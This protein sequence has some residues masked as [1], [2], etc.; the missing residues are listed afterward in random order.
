MVSDEN[1][2]SLLEAIIFRPLHMRK[3]LD[4]SKAMF[5]SDNVNNKSVDAISAGQNDAQSISSFFTYIIEKLKWEKLKEFYDDENVNFEKW[6]TL[7]SMKVAFLSHT[8][9]SIITRSIVARNQQKNMNSFRNRN[10]SDGLGK[11]ITKSI[12]SGAIMA[13][14]IG[15]MMIFI[16][17]FAT[18][19]EHFSL[20]T[21]PCATTVIPTIFCHSLGVKPLQA[22]KGGLMLGVFS[23]LIILGIS[24]SYDLS[25]DETYQCFKNATEIDLREERES[26]LYKFMKEHRIRKKEKI[27]RVTSRSICD[28]IF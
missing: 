15:C 20:W 16:T 6:I 12:F 24:F 13:A 18:W 10:V 17:Q 14:N 26:E 7:K 23:S 9:I 3:Y 21:V 11:C 2:N 25:I 19:S 8:M 4:F 28:C 27:I 22:L 1:R 5:I